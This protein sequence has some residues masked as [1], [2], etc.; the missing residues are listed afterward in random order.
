M[1]GPAH[2]L[3]LG[4]AREHPTPCPLRTPPPP[5]ES[6]VLTKLESAERTFKELSVWGNR[7]GE[8][9]GRA[10]RQAERR[11]KAGPCPAPVVRLLFAA[12]GEEQLQQGPGSPTPCASLLGCCL[13]AQVRLADPEVAGNPSEYM[14]IAKSAAEIEDVRACCLAFCL[15]FLAGLWPGCPDTKC[16]PVAHLT[17]DASLP[18]SEGR[19]MFLWHVPGAPPSP[20]CASS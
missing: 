16:L 18:G 3:L 1:P 14:K 7:V 8:G 9:R 11:G 4:L 6:Y 2:A 19:A 5:Q 13:E 10:G 15:A 12:S 17:A 20:V